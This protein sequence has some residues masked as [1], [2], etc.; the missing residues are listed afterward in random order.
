MIIAYKETQRQLEECYRHMGNYIHDESV[1]AE[2]REMCKNCKIYCGLQHDFEEC[3]DRPCFRFW[4]AYE[5]LEW[6][7][8]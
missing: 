3:K 5:Y 2:L 7:N 4:L 8:S 1:T 6:G